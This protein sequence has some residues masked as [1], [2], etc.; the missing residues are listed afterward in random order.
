MLQGQKF[1]G[2]LLADGQ[3]RSHETAETFA[4]PSAWAIHCKKIVNPEKKSGCGWASVRR[5]AEVRTGSH[6]GGGGY[7]GGGRNAC[8]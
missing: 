1:R 4:S 5:G 7:R 2:D 6:R 8:R 3:I